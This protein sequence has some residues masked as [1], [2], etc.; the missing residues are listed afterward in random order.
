MRCQIVSVF[1]K[2]VFTAFEIGCLI[3]FGVVGYW[4]L[5][6][7]E[8]LIIKRQPIEIVNPGKS[9]A[10]GD[11]LLYKIE[12]QKNM[13][14]HGVL[15]RKIINSYK[16]DLEEAEATEHIGIGRSVVPVR[17]PRWITPGVHYLRWSVS[18]KV[19]PIRTVSVSVD[20]EKF[21]VVERRA[22]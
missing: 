7:Y 6:P 18:Y 11:L 9:V 8:P 5:Y 1:R 4:L 20:S 10:A 2:V 15:S 22:S 12:W 13:N 3:Y 16:V 21:T 17:I 14:I 19:N